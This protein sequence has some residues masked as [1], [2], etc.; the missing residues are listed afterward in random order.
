[1]KMF[2]QYQRQFISFSTKESGFRSNRQVA[3]TQQSI[4]RHYCS[5]TM[6]FVNTESISESDAH[7]NLHLVVF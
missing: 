7:A 6:A 3:K 1:M 4:C 2:E 5:I